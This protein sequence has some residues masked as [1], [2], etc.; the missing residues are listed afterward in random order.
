MAYFFSL[1]VLTIRACRSNRK[2]EEVP[3][4]QKM[5]LGTIYE[6]LEMAFKN[7]KTDFADKKMILKK[8]EQ[9]FFS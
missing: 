1:N 3:Q 6:I 7:K 5:N 4:Q 8:Y 9:I 2:A